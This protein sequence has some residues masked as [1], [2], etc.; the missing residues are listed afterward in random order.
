MV[1]LPSDEDL[2]LRAQ[3]GCPDSFEELVRRFQVPLVHFLR[4]RAGTEE[5]EDLAQ[6]TLLRAY[7]NLHRYRP[8]WK[9]GTWLFTIARRLNLNR[10]RRREPATDS[11][12]LSEVESPVASPAAIVAEEE[13]RQRLWETAA[14]VLSEP[15]ITA[16]WLYYV[17]E[18]AVKEIARVVGRSRVA[19]K[20]M[21]FRSRKKLLPM[22]DELQNDTPNDGNQPNKTS[23]PAVEVSHG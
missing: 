18:M 4:Q 19:V 20:T 7:E 16:L 2:A 12:A 22:L 11:D 6:D 14:A 1:P 15:Q 23:R 21:L 13:N 5:A 17:E 8:A 3:R 10:M 9:F